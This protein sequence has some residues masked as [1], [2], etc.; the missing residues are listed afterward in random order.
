MRTKYISF[1]SKFLDDAIVFHDSKLQNEFRVVGVSP[2]SVTKRNDIFINGNTYQQKMFIYDDK[3]RFKKKVENIDYD[4][5]LLDFL[6]ADDIFLSCICYDNTESCFTKSKFVTD[7]FDTLIEKGI[8]VKEEVSPILLKSER[9]KEL[10]TEFANYLL[11][12]VDLDK[13]I[14]VSWHIPYI[15]FDE[16]KVYCNDIAKINQMNSF[17]GLCEK[18]FMDVIHCKVVEMPK[19]LIT[20]SK[21]EYVRKMT[22]HPS[23][24]D[25]LS[26]KL[27]NIEDIT[28]KDNICEAEYSLAV[29]EYCKTV[30]EHCIVLNNFLGEYYDCFDNHILV[31]ER[32]NVVIEGANSS[33]NIEETKADRL[34]IT[35]GNNAI[36]HVG[37]G[38]TF[39][40]YCHLI[41]NEH[42]IILGKDDMLSTKVICD[43]TQADIIIEDHVWVGY[44]AKV[45]GGAVI[46]EGS[47]VGAR[48]VVNSIKPNNCIIVGETGRI[49]KRDICWEREPYADS[50]LHYEYARYTEE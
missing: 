11:S 16:G 21:C 19:N 5:F 25:Y 3:E 6:W 1:G 43:A 17:I 40:E 30:S 33:A 9:L 35:L 46:G 39:A 15:Y 22:L 29:K 41:A 38:T 12:F 48:T 20:F 34:K 4:Y 37:K 7:N 13:I 50:V 27:A 45:N 2:F 31:K 14:L 10:V 18:T 8:V 28:L 42:T 44:Q 36:I 23:C 24:I 32:C 26:K 49:I 47:I